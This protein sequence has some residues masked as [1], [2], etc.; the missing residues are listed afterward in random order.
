MNTEALGQ[1][2]YREV[3]K[4]TENEQLGNLDKVV[5]HVFVKN[6]FPKSKNLF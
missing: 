2:F 5:E 1:L 6:S 3:T 4:I